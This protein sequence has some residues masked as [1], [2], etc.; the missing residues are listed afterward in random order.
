VALI[1]T[2]P[3]LKISVPFRRGEADFIPA[4]EIQAFMADYGKDKNGC[5]PLF[6][7]VWPLGPAIN[8]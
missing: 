2:G 8:P 4:E 6:Y 3:R 5:F 1:S 7:P